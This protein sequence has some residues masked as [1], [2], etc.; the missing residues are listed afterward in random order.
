VRPFLLDVVCDCFDRWTVPG[1]TLL[2][3]AAHP[4]SPVGAQGINIALRDAVVA[5]N[6]FIPLLRDSA[7]PADL[8]AAATAFQAERIAEVAPIQKLQRRGPRLLFGNEWL[9]TG[10]VWQ[11]RL[12]Q[13]LG[14]LGWIARRFGSGPKVFAFGV[15]EVRLEV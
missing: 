15:T 2:G 4:M 6:H 11:V 1:M 7:S 3:D 13:R 8:D 10:L 14:L 9:L 12:L 5:A